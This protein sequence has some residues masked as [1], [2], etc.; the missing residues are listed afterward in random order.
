[1]GFACVAGQDESYGAGRQK[2]DNGGGVRRRIFASDRVVA[3]AIKEKQEGLIKLWRVQNI[4]HLKLRRHTRR[5]GALASLGNGQ[6]S[7]IHSHGIE[8]LLSEPNGVAAG[9]A[10]QIERTTGH[11]RPLRNDAL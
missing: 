11:D 9:A 8:P 5:L 4:G 1:M 2:L 3:A 6:G 7:D 10:P